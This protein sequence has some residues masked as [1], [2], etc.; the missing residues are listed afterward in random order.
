M[1]PL[2]TRRAISC[3]VAWWCQGPGWGARTGPDSPGHASFRCSEV[4]C[5]MSMG[6]IVAPS[7]NDIWTLRRH[8]INGDVGGNEITQALSTV[9]RS[10]LV[11]WRAGEASE[12]EGS[13]DTRMQDVCTFLAKSVMAI[14]Y[15]TA[16]L[17]QRQYHDN[18]QLAAEFK[19]A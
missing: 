5:R 11:V 9:T 10:T 4:G 19:D 12:L 14:P 15:N 6:K 16:Q 7:L 17:W 2:L 18:L 13:L 3:T 8:V 1:L